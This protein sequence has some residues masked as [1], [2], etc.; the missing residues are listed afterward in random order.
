MEF[1]GSANYGDYQDF[2]F[3]RAGGWGT[4]FSA[5]R[6]S[7]G[8]RF[9]MKFF[10]YTSN[11][12]NMAE[13][14]KEIRLMVS[15]RGVDGVVQL[16]GVFSD[17]AMGYMPNKNRRFQD[18]GYPVIVMEMID[19][20]ELLDRIMSSG[21]ISEHYVAG[22]FKSA[23][24]ALRGIH[25]R[26]FVHRD[27]KL[28][29][30][31][32]M[33]QEADSI[34]K[35]IDFGLMVSLPDASDIYSSAREHAPCGTAG[36]FAP[37]TLLRK[38]YSFKTDIWQLGCILYS[39]LCGHPPYSMELRYQRQITDQSFY[40]MTGPEWENISEAAKD[41]VVKMLTKDS[42]SRISLEEICLHP[43]L[44]GSAPCTELGNDYARR[45]KSLALRGRL[46]R[47]FQYNDIVRIKYFILYVIYIIFYIFISIG[48]SK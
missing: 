30:I 33:S 20:G 41:I 34:V 28:D 40:P 1:I 45:V 32:L 6:I 43:W 37:E 39:T 10:G 4:V 18:R 5:Q 38:E 36:Y 27:L 7:D 22:M 25:S 16:E 26:R 11:R 47:F 12:P 14:E 3:V 31:L 35:L 2:T 15:L 46:K 19:G 42:S 24:D 44:S 13:I 8:K 9:A 48:K 23:V 21:K 29:N 17:T